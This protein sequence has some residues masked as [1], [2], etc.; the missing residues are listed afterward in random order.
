MK[1]SVWLL[2]LA[3]ILTTGCV[4]ETPLTTEH[5]L[6]IDPALLGL[7]ELVPGE[8][9]GDPDEDRMVVMRW[10][11]TEYLVQIPLGPEG[12]FFRAYPVEVGGHSL[13]QAEY[14]GN[15]GKG[16]YPPEETF[17]P[18]ITYEIEEGILIAG[19]LNPKVVDGE[20]GSILRR[21]TGGSKTSK[22]Q[23]RC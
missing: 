4:H 12:D 22:S 8:A 2:F 7:W 1:H 16:L 9:K 11:D 19:S 15:H 10:S 3:I 17:F 18:I 23:V 6:A 20:I 14:V 13:I 21:T 5:N